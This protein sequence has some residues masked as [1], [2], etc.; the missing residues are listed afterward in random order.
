MDA[1]GVTYPQWD[2]RPGGITYQVI[3]GCEV[4][5][6]VLPDGRVFRVIAE[7]DKEDRRWGRVS[8]QRELVRMVEWV[9]AG[10]PD[11]TGRKQR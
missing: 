6:T 7:L 2:V 3:A 5:S 8:A 9:E 10:S 4:V 11:W 1:V